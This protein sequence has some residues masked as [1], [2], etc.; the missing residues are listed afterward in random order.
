MDERPVKNCWVKVLIKYKDKP[1]EVVTI[2]FDSKWNHCKRGTGRDDCTCDEQSDLNACCCTHKTEYNESK[3][4]EHQRKFTNCRKGVKIMNEETE[5][6][7]LTAGEKVG[8]VGIVVAIFIAII[9][10]FSMF[11]SIKAGEVKV[12]T[13][14]GG[15]TGRV[16]EPGLNVIIPFIEGTKTLSTKKVTY[17]TAAKEKQGTSDADYK[18]F[19][20]DTNTKDGQPVDISYTV[21]FSVDPTKAVWVVNN[22]GGMTNLVEKII[23][24]ESRVLARNVPRGYEASELYS[25]DVTEIQDKIFK[26]LK[27]TFE[28]NGLVLDFVGVREITFTPE[29]VKAIEAKQIAAVQIDTEKN[30]AE[31]AK[32]RKEAK[33]TEAQ[34]TA[35]TQRLQRETLSDIVIQK[36]ELDVKQTIADALKISAEKGQKIV[37]DS[38]LGDTSNGFLY[39]LPK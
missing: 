28:A 33:I 25:K 20:V 9:A 6:T 2:G 17:E 19:P 37:P 22:I 36:T 13:R 12:V 23:K 29:Y 39:Q 38:V 7:E 34:A 8:I 32:Y 5:S 31:Q 1:S 18:D 26:D 16:L 35:E 21:R 10:L 14:F 15:T 3:F 4:H 30:N 24:T 27:P 11:R